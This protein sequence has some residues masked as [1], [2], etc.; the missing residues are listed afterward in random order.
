MRSGTLRGRRKFMFEEMVLEGCFE[1]ESV[2]QNLNRHTNFLSA[3]LVF[4]R[5]RT[6]LIF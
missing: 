6:I 2:L 3:R 4:M 5:A 1:L